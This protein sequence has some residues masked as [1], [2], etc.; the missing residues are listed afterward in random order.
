MEEQNKNELARN[1]LSVVAGVLAAIAAGAVL[2][3]LI[4]MIFDKYFHLH[5]FTESPAGAWKNDL[6][7]GIAFGSWFFLSSLIGGF[8]CT[9]IS[10]RYDLANVTVSAMVGVAL[11][12][13]ISDGEIFREKSL[14]SWMILLCIPIGFFAG[15][16]AGVLY[17]R[18]KSIRSSA[19]K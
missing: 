10:T 2:W 5:L 14:G 1:I 13:F 17:K 15:E 18:K 11:F 8:I 12:F 3:P 6:V 9:I 4:N 16:L 19:N 7:I